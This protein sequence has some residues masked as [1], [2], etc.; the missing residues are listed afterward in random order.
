MF[1][2][3]MLSLFHLNRH[4]RGLF[5]QETQQI[6]HMLH[7]IINIPIELKPFF[8]PL[9]PIFCN[10]GKLCIIHDIL[11]VIKTTLFTRF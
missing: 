5:A 7:F 4:Y 8:V 9:V 6:A 11:K 3:S 2:I 1:E 10:P